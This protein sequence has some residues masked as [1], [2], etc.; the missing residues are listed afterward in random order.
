[1]F[2]RNFPGNNNILGA[3]ASECPRGYGPWC[4]Q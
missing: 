3:T 2:K 1:M 4:S